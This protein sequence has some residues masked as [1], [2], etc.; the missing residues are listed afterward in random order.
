MDHDI[1]NL[2]VGIIHD[3]ELDYNYNSPYNPGLNYPEYPFNKLSDENDI[4][5]AVRNLFLTLGLD[6]I[7]ADKESW[8]PFGDFIKPGCNVL[9]KP[10]FVFDHNVIPEF[11]T[12]CL[13]THGSIIRAVIDYVYIALEGSGNIIIGDSP[14]QSAD[15]NRIINI[16]G[17]REVADFYE[18]NANFEIKIIDFREEKGYIDNLRGIIREELDGDPLGYSLID[19]KEC[20]EFF[21]SAE[22]CE[23]LRVTNYD[24]EDLFK[25]HN[26]GQHSYLISQTVLNSDVIINLPKLKTHRKAGFSVALKNIV[27]IN[28]VKNCLPHHKI[29]S[30]EEKGDAYLHKSVRKNLLGRLTEKMDEKNNLID[31]NFYKFLFYST[32]ILKYLIPDKDPYFEGSWYG[33][34]TINKTICDLNKIL[35]YVD[36]K[37]S[38]KDE[39]QRLEFT[40][41]DGIIGGEQEGP[42]QPKPKKCGVLVAGFNPVAVDT[43]CSRI[44]GFD[45]D[46][47]PTITQMI[48]Q[49]KFKFFGKDDINR[50]R[51]KSKICNNL[52]E[53]TS[54]FKCNFKPSKG[55]EGHIEFNNKKDDIK[56]S[57]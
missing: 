35:F 45:N 32:I 54:Y 33:N 9:I 15:F 2:D 48:H 28:A 38:L 56:H 26:R 37:G 23:K 53:I 42:L 52:D 40:L 31:Y 19:L 17:L 55:W 8:N 57:I 20:S 51:I 44:M 36:K 16:S 29:G 30:K 1:N 5:D 6:E 49:N 41:V 4:Y 3:E 22:D 14:I 43:V 18:K 27:G 13:I 24:K 7:N 34:N 25:H 46:K 47:I 10:N 50:I 11:G 39:V 12:D 21:Q